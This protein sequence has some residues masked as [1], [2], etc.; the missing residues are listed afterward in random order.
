MRKYSSSKEDIRG[1]KHVDGEG[2]GEGRE[3]KEGRQM[4]GQETKD[5][6]EKNVSYV[7]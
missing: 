1:R 7:K 2:E 5:E 4:E 3:N 6:E